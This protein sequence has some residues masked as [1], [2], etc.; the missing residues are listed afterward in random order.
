MSAALAA[1]GVV[2]ALYARSSTGR[3]RTIDVALLDA[4]SWTTQ[5]RWA[6][7]VVD[8]AEPSLLGNGHQ[9][10]APHGVYPCADGWL[11]LHVT[12][13][14]QWQPLAGLLDDD[15][16]RPDL[17]TAACSPGPLVSYRRCHLGVDGDTDRRG[18][19]R[20]TGPGWCASRAGTGP[21]GRC[22]PPAHQCPWD[23]A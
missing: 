14:D 9:A 3:G 4:V 21:P 19:C 18:G 2:C 8:E 5:L 6:E 20:G 1:F 16:A 11:S 15:R 10:D 22:G 13:N 23:A 12:S 7:A 17:A